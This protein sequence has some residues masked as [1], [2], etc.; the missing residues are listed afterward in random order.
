MI[1]PNKMKSN[2]LFPSVMSSD[3]QQ[4]L[5]LS[6]HLPPCWLEA[7]LP[8]GGA[9]PGSHSWQLALHPVG[10]QGP[11]PAAVPPDPRAQGTWSAHHFGKSMTDYLHLAPR[12]RNRIFK[13]NFI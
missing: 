6:F 2:T 1:T 9:R 13:A 5:I 11:A 3:E 12:K 8:L 4:L 7:F 10:L